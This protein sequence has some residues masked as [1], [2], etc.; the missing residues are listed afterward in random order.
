MNNYQVDPIDF[1]VKPRPL[2]VR[3]QIILVEQIQ[4]ITYS[5]SPSTYLNILGKYKTNKTEVIT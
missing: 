1:R 3:I 5:V 2:R 4:I